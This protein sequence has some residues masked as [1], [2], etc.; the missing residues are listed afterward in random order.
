MFVFGGVN[1][2]AEFVG[3]FPELGFNRFSLAVRVCHRFHFYRVQCLV[4]LL[5]CLLVY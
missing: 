4:N 1:V 3:G 2:F 5:F